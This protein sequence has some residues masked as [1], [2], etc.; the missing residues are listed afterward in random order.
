[1]PMTQ[2]DLDN[3]IK[4]LATLV[5]GEDALIGNIITEVTALIAKVQAGATPADLTTEVTA[6][7]SMASD[8]QTQTANLQASVTAA[9]GVTGV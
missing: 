2:T 7:Q 5:T 3:A 6:L 4:A 1:M 9:K 8:L